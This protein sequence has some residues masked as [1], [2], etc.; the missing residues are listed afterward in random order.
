MY[1]S[2]YV[3]DIQIEISLSY[4]FRILNDHLLLYIINQKEKSNY[5]QL[6][7]ENP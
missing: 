2:L 7:M 5:H 4:F 1:F 3:N 6:L